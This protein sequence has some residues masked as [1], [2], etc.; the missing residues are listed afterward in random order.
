MPDPDGPVCQA[1]F[2]GGPLPPSAPSLGIDPQAELFGGFD[3]SHVSGGVRVADGPAVLIHAGL[4][5]H[6]AELTLACA[7]ALSRDPA[8]PP[9]AFGGYDGNLDPV[10]QHIHFRNVLFT[11]H[12]EDELFG[13]TDFVL[14][15][16]GDVRANVL[17]G[18]FDGFGGDLQTRQ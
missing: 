3:S 17:G 15:A 12:G 4:R 9:L 16:L 6:A 8:G 11:N 2:A 13:A 1:G 14:V 10:H 18:S 5:E 7:G